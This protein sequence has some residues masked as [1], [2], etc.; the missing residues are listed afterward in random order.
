[1]A[2]GKGVSWFR[3]VLAG[4][5]AGRLASPIP[6]AYD[7]CIAA[8]VK[9]L[10]AQQLATA[11]SRST[12]GDASYARQ[13][14]RSIGFGCLQKP[15]VFAQFHKLWLSGIRKSLQGHHLPAAFVQCVV[16]KAAQI[17]PSQL[18]KLVQAGS[19]SESKYGEKLGRECRSTVTG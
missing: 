11:V 2:Q 4:E 9:Q 6:A 13:L 5:V 17:G 7:K 3:G 18:S 14:G 1:M 12:T 16:A 10:S 19:A 15:A 8:G